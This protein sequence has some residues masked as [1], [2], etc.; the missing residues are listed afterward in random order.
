MLLAC[1]SC[2]DT[3][4]FDLGAEWLGILSYQPSPWWWRFCLLSWE[5][6]GVPG[7]GHPGLAVTEL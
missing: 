1:P 4:S 3:I 5:K 7:S 6:L 2:W